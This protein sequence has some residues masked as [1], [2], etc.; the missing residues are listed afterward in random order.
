MKP[1]FFVHDLGIFA[2]SDLVMRTCVCQ[3]VLHCIASLRQLQGM[4]CLPVSVFQSIFG[5][6]VLR[7]LNNGNWFVCQPIL[8][9]DSSQFK[10]Q[11]RGSSSGFGVPITLQMCL[12]AF[13]GYV[14]WSRLHTRL[15]Y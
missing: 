1:V 11:Q 15:L 2:D 3:T 5:T 6:L 12:V 4:R 9:N 8:F 14:Y 7:R 10:M 13:S